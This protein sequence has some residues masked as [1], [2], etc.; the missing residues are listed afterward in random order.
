MWSGVSGRRGVRDCATLGL[1]HMRDRGGLRTLV[2]RSVRSLQS[3]GA[4]RARVGDSQAKARTFG[5]RDAR[6]AAPP[7]RARLVVGGGQ[8]AVA[9]SQQAPTSSRAIAIVT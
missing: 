8:G 6:T 7:R 5:V 9:I 4:T 1:P 2:R 3:S